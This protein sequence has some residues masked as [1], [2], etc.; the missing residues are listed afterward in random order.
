MACRIIEADVRA[1]LETSLD[2]G[3]IQVYIAVANGILSAEL[4]NS[5]LGA[6]TMANIERWLTAHL[7]A[8]T[9]ERMGKSEKLGEAAI[10]YIGSFGIGLDSTPYGQTAK[11]LDSTGKL[12]NMGK[13]SIKIQAIIEDYTS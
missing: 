11:M 10:T 3:D 13:K 9:R 8:S 2:D 12:A 5:G 6:A 7:I 1:I 4:S